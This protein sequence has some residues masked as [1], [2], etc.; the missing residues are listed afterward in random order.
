MTTAA[1]DSIFLNTNILVYASVDVSPSYRVARAA[2]TA[3]GA[4]QVP[5][6]ISRQVLRE[7]LATLARPHVGIPMTELTA[8]VHQFEV[9]LQMAEDGHLL[10]AQLLM[11][12]EQGYSTQ[13][14]DMNIVATTQTVGVGRILTNNPLQCYSL[15]DPGHRRCTA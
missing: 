6:W 10:T 8:A 3:Y 2:I 4:G 7:Y 1:A 11:L 5:L 15:P 13:V 14:H 9:R 12:L